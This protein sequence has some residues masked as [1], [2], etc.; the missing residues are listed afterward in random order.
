MRL[1]NVIPCACR[2]RIG[3]YQAVLQLASPTGSPGR[4]REEKREEKTLEILD[5]VTSVPSSTLLAEILCEFLQ[6]LQ[7]LLVHGGL[8]AGQR[9]QHVRHA[10]HR[11]QEFISR[12]LQPRHLS[13]LRISWRARG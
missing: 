10:N 13:G 9:S 2:L 5:P 12:N 1:I 3:F 4:K 6:L 11:L 7:V 8:R